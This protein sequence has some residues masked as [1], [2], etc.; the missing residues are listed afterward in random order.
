MEKMNREKM[1][2]DEGKNLKHLYAAQI[3]IPLLSTAV[4]LAGVGTAF[5]SQ[6]NANRTSVELKRL[7]LSFSL[8]QSA[9]AGSINCMYSALDAADKARD[10]QMDSSLI[11]LRSYIAQVE[12]YVSS[13]KRDKLHSAYEDF[14]LYCRKVEDVKFRGEEL[15]QELK[16]PQGVLENLRAILLKELFD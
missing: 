15:P 5:L 11:K 14:A 9:Y 2:M 6:V 12:P 7:E 3:L 16:E 13:D 1:E 8:K 4:A 10:M